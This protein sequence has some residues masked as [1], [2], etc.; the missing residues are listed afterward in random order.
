MSVFCSLVVTC[1]ERGDLLALLFVMCSCVF[2]TFPYGVLFQVWYFAFLFTLLPYFVYLT[3]NLAILLTERRSLGGTPDAK[4]R[5]SQ[6]AES[7]KRLIY[8]L[9][10]ELVS[11]VCW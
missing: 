10:T 8:V 4:S 2:V 6:L 1:C 9:T 3:I 11:L 5:A 7:L